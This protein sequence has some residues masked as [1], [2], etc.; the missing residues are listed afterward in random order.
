MMLR[1]KWH[2]GMRGMI[3]LSRMA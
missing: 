1:L 2:S 3:G